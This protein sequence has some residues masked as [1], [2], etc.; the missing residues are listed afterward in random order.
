MPPSRDRWPSKSQPD[1]DPTSPDWFGREK[2]AECEMQGQHG[3]AN[4]KDFATGDILDP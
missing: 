3:P 2:R 4:G 1:K